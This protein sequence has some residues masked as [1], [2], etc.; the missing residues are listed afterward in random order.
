MP[1][2]FEPWIERTLRE[3]ADAGEFD[4]LAG[5]G[6]PIPDLDLPYDPAWWARKWIQRHRD[7]DA[8]TEVA[9]KVQRLLPRILSGTDEVRVRSDLERLNDRIAA[10]N[11]LLPTDAELEPLPVEEVIAGWRRRR[12]CRPPRPG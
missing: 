1:Q 2:E 5:A 7:L 9:G 3:A 11:A 4:D 8:A 10:V 6:L 12:V